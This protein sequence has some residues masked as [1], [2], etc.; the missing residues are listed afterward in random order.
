MDPYLGEIKLMPFSRDLPGWLPC[1]GALL[2]I[3]TYQAL[4]ALLGTYFGG[5]GKTTFALPDL[6]GRTPVSAGNTVLVG[7]AAGAEAVTLTAAQLPAH[8][9]TMM[10]SNTDGTTASQL[11]AFYAQVPVSAASSMYAAPSTPAV[12]IN[13]EMVTSVG[14][15]TTHSNIQPYLAMAYFIAIQ[16]IFPMRP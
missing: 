6:R 13:S 15:G 4:Y 2:Q 7:T 10:A 9:H 3:K 8:A 14:G 12:T 11:N 5:D 1:D 16:G